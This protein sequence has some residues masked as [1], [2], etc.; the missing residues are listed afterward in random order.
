MPQER[1]NAEWLVENNVG[2]AIRSVS[3]VP[4]AVRD[5]LLDLSAYRDRV[6]CHRNRAVFEVVSLMNQLLTVRESGPAPQSLALVD[7]VRI[8]RGSS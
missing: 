4:E 2:L 1:Y 3:Q 8:V 5:L 7:R 6:A